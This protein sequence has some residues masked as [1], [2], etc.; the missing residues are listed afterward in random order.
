MGNGRVQ[1]LVDAPGR[2]LAAS[3]S[4]FATAP[5][6]LGS[7]LKLGKA[8]AEEEEM[9]SL[10]AES[11]G[12]RGRGT[13]LDETARFLSKELVHF[14]Q[15]L[16][17][18]YIALFKMTPGFARELF[19]SGVY[20]PN[21]TFRKLPYRRERSDLARL[22]EWN[23][24]WI[25][26]EDFDPRSWIIVLLH[27]YIDNTGAELVAYKL[28]R[29]GYQIY[30]VRYPFLQSVRRTAIELM[31]MLETIHHREHGK[32]IVPIGH[33]LGGFIWD[34]LL[35]HRPQL[36]KRY[37]MPLYISMG[38]PRFGTLPAYLGVGRSAREMRPDSMLVRAHLKRSYPPG[39]EV[40]P[41]ISRFDVF[42]LPIETTL[43]KRGINYVFSETGHLA[44]ATRNETVRAI[45]EIMASPREILEA[46]A[47]KRPFFPSGL[48]WL[49]SK[50]PKP[51][52]ERL[53]MAGILDYVLDGPEPPE[54][55]IRI[56]HHDVRSGRLPLLKRGP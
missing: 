48:T 50:L 11:P 41:F 56:V 8:P 33:S 21:L 18:E 44:Q 29:L 42:V 23:P 35:L 52:L 19:R 6:S 49:L 2:R 45:E 13:G 32:R 55:W 16:I 10:V 12:Q 5:A 40:Y 20:G 24:G 39:L 15:A 14:Y 4:R 43:L 37:S 54:F 46:R 51:A 30:L 38:S 7:E 27:G 1:P 25:F 22:R 28:A 53:G 3:A 36:A 34:H 9:G 31:E 17:G 26:R 47:E